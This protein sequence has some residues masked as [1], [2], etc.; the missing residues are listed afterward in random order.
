M[1]INPH[2]ILVTLLVMNIHPAHGGAAPATIVINEIHYDED[3]KTRRAEFIEIHNATPDAVDLSDWKLTGGVDYAFPEDT[4]IAGGAYLV[5]AEDPATIRSQFSFRG[6]FGPWSGKLRNSGETVSLRDQHGTVISRADYRLGFPW[7]T[8]GDAVG[9]PAVSPSIQLIH[10]L[11]ETELGGSWRSAPPTAGSRNAPYNTEAPPQVRQVSHTPKQPASDV[12]VVI[13]ARVTDPEGVS[14]VSLAYQTIRP[15]GYF[16][17]YLK[18]SSNGSPNFDPRYELP[19]SW[20]PVPMADDGLNDDLLAGDG[21]FTVTLPGTVQRNRYLIR[22]RITVTDASGNSVRVPY[23]DDPQPN[24]AFFVYDGTPDWAGSIRAGDPPV[25]FSGELMSSIP[26][27]FLLSTSSWVTDSQ[28]GGYGG[29]EYLWPGTLI[30]DG[31]V[32]DHIQYRPRGGVHRFQYGKNFWKFDFNRGHRFQARDEYGKKYDSEWSKLNFSSIVQQVNFGHRG[33]QGLFEGVG[34]RLFDLCGV[35][36]CET[37]HLQFYVID[38]P[39]STGTT[40]YDTDYYGLF[41]AVEQMDGQFLDQHNLPDANLYKIEGHSG[42]SNNQ[43]PNQVSN[44]SDVT[45]FISAYRSGNPTA[46]WWREN[47]DIDKYLSYRTIVEGI[48]HYDIAYGKNY[49][50]YHNPETEKFEVH[51]WDLDLTFANNM[52]GNGNHDFKSKVALNPSFNTDYQN[53]VREIMDLLYNRDEGYK[54]IDETVKFVWT[55]GQP[56]LVDA[57]RRQW[58]NHPRLNHKDRYYDIASGNNFA[59]MIRVVKNYFGTRGNWMKSTILTQNS[60]IPNRPSLTF[61]GAPE[62]PIDDLR[63]TC[64]EYSSPSGSPFAAMEW[65]VGEIHNPTVPNYDPL[66]P[67]VYEI[68]G[69]FESGELTTFSTAYQFPPL[70][71]HVDRTYRAR[72]RFKDSARRWSNWSSPLQFSTTVP[73]IADHLQDLRIS[74]FMYHPPE[75][76][77]NETAISTNRDEFEFVELKNVGSI[78]LDLRDVRFTKGIDFAFGGSAVEAL[79]PDSFALVV[80]NIAAFEGR[81][82]TG[83]PIAGEYPED[84]LRNSGERLKLSYGAGL[85]I[86]DLDEYSD[87]FPWPASADGGGFSLT[88]ID[89]NQPLSPDHNDAASWRLSRFTGGSPGA[90][91]EIS[92]AAWMQLHGVSDLQSDDDRDG[93]DALLEF[94]L[95]SDPK[96]SSSDL[97]PVATLET[98]MVNDHADSYLTI[99]F[100]HQVATDEVGRI[101]EFS[102]DLVTWTAG[103]IL[104]S[105]TPSGNNDGL[106]TERWRSPL[107]QSAGE[108]QFARLRVQAGP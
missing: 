42:S 94:F 15:G 37:H 56:S 47:L 79:Q 36:A 5:I 106:V 48:H 39:R 13:S 9:S 99:S 58:D 75:P 4:N 61:E 74:E 22:Y 45:S 11:L 55:N 70:A 32:Y 97:L 35:E 90:D 50:Y 41:L 76:V 38:S 95:G 87:K 18:F 60:Q 84:N 12:P 29:S 104:V 77:G 34:F 30:Y 103:G 51:P 68:K 85:P 98:I 21:I 72:V 80:K 54:L 105:Q 107:P 73:D 83:F 24:F 62:F 82:G 108:Q 102:S 67:N 8:V 88:L 81:Y 52:Y 31:E 1:K 93:L 43:G 40:Q 10:P 46:R 89:V 7:P 101:V 3:I 33:E 26:T 59:G 91:D 23:E 2:L 49:F 20:N 25:N 96:A 14:S 86:H 19:T 6:A 28:F 57:D 64:T 78:P 63:F 27:Y 92:L 66:Q 17:R 16:C 69:A 53:R 100:Q 44:R 65:R 71:V